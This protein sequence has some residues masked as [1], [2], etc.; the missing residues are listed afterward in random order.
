M[1]KMS[2]FCSLWGEGSF[3]K[4]LLK[5]FNLTAKHKYP[6]FSDLLATYVK[7]LKIETEILEMRDFALSSI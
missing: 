5:L 6:I 1:I 2:M 3:I 4:V 7:K